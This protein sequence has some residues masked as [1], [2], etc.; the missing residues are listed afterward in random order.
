[1]P[2]P[3]PA[4]SWRFAPTSRSPD[5]TIVVVNNPGR[6][7]AAITVTAGATVQHATLEPQSES[8]MELA[9][10]QRASALTVR[11]SVPIIV[12]R[13]DIRKGKSYASYGTHT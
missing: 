6:R 5:Q 10:G 11:S 1:M 2:A 8:E 12:Q 7:V 9:A 13:I 4:A 3:V